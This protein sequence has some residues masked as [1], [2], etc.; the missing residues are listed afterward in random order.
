[1]MADVV[2]FVNALVVVKLHVMELDVALVLV[3]EGPVRTVAARV[4]QVVDDAVMVRGVVR[5]NVVVN[6]LLVQCPVA[7]R[8][9]VVNRPPGRH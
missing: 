4:G 5:P 8:R 3:V 7:S 6:R 9:A 2:M 1:M